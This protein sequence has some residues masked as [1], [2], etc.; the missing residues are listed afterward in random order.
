MTLLAADGITVSY[1]RGS[2]RLEAARPALEGVSLTIGGAQRL[3]LVG[4]S[5]SGK[6]TLARALM[7]LV[8]PSSGAVT[9]DGRPLTE[10]DH[11][12][13]QR[14]RRSCQMVF[15]DPA[16]ALDPRQSVL[17]S[18]IE[19]MRIQRLVPR[20]GR[21]RRGL[22]ALERVGIEM[23]VA[24]RR[25]ASLSG[26]QLQRVAIARALVLQPDVLV[27]D[28]AVSG[29]DVSVQANV[30]GLLRDIH[31]E[32][33]LSFLFISHDIAVIQAA[34]EW[35]AVMFGGQIMESGP[36][37]LV[38]NSPL[39][40]YS[41]DL[42]AAVPQLTR[43]PGTPSLVERAGSIRSVGS[44]V[45]VESSGCVYAP[46]CAR[47]SE[48]CWSSPPPLAPVLDAGADGRM[49]SCY[50]PL[51][52]QV[53]HESPTVEAEEAATANDSPI[54]DVKFDPIEGEE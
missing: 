23:E 52:L 3:G 17:R 40:P 25:P 45:P 43:K 12:E 49:V 31:A 32:M 8:A 38:A 7:G 22:E 13:Y 4:E 44:Q 35:V 36:T 47:A 11:A 34:T 41:A 37:D 48:Q 16:S 54:H 9:I 29:L 33:Q 53:R 6:S 51:P 2:G 24:R 5:G 10:L 20:N 50:H 19:P 1:A 18:V 27:L 28:E 46:R 21:E 30:L 26:G 15:Q 42:L 39:H 14:Y